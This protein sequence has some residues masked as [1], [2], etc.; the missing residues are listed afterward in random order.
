MKV[1]L[2]IASVLVA[3]LG[4]ASVIP[5]LF[6]VMMFDAPGATE[7]PATIA[8]AISVAS[9]PFVCFGAIA[10]AWSLFGAATNGLAKIAIWAP[11]INLIVGAIAFYC[12]LTF[13]DGKFNG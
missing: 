13:Y 5:A 9:C 2:V 8:L 12:L 6:S 7:N 1:Y 4:L 3:L 11:I 10:K